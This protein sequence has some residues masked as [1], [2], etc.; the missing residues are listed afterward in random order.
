MHSATLNL[1]VINYTTT[2]LVPPGGTAPPTSAIFPGSP[3]AS[4]GHFGCPLVVGTG[5]TGKQDFS[6]IGGVCAFTPD[7][8]T[9]P[10]P[11]HITISGCTVASVRKHTPI[12]ASFLLGLPGI[13]LLGSLRGG[14]RRHKRLLPVLGLSLVLLTLLVGAGC[15]GG[16]KTSTGSYNVL[17]QGTGSDGTVYSAVVPVMVVPWNN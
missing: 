9:I 3:G 10:G 4:I 14:K 15:G 8:A 7:S 2:V 12:Y 17:V 11:V 16:Q 13:V 5:L 6:I 1:T